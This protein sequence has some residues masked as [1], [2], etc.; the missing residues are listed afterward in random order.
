MDHPLSIIIPIRTNH[1]R[2]WPPDHPLSIIIP[3]R[4]QNPILRNLLTTYPTKLT[5]T[6]S[7]Q[8][9]DH[10]SWLSR[11]TIDSNNFWHFINILSS[12]H[13]IPGIILSMTTAA[14]LPTHRVQNW[15]KHCRYILQVGRR[16]KATSV[17][18]S[19]SHYYIY[20]MYGLY[21]LNFMFMSI[22]NR[23]FVAC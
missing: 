3:S 14:T 12:T 8:F 17:N 9:S 16:S 23:S 11:S 5:Q 15:F 6:P 21:A 10:I 13:V 20:K 4:P 19:W 22:V 1:A 7:P 18:K 2:S